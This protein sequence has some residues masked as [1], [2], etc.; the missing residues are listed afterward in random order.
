M[1][2]KSLNPIHL[3][4]L[5]SK[6]AFIFFALIKIKLTNYQD[7]SSMIWLHKQNISTENNSERNRG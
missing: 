3:I 2:G 7:A 1:D 4:F 6:H 5:N